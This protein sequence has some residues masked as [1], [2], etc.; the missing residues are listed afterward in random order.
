LNNVSLNN[1]CIDNSL[2]FL[3][4]SDNVKLFRKAVEIACDVMIKSESV[5]NKLDGL[6][7]DG[8]CG[9]SMRRAANGV[10]SF[11]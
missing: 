2:I 4:D 10:K 8:D 3:I 1:L 6:V 5:L 11:E 7:G 9:T